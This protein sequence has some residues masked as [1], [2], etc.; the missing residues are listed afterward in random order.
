MTSFSQTAV[1]IVILLCKSWQCKTKFSEKLT[2]GLI[3]WLIEVTI[4][5]VASSLFE[6]ETLVLRLYYRRTYC[7]IK[8]F[9][10]FDCQSFTFKI[11]LPSLFTIN[12]QTHSL[13]SSTAWYNNGWNKKTGVWH[14]KTGMGEWYSLN[15][16]CHSYEVQQQVR[17]V[18][19]LTEVQC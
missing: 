6:F 17:Y 14:I 16:L 4:S 12:Y 3:D 8:R 5:T 13:H 15:K 9:F 1:C 19:H 2:D 18:R 11:F 10:Q 7:E